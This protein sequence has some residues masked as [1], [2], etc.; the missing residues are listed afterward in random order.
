MW[1]C[2]DLANYVICSKMG[3]CDLTPNKTFNVPI[4]LPPM[5]FQEPPNEA[6][7]FLPNTKI[8]IPYDMFSL[9]TTLGPAKKLTN[10][11]KPTTSGSQSTIKTNADKRPASDHLTIDQHSLVS[12]ISHYFSRSLY[13]LHMFS[14]YFSFFFCLS[15]KENASLFDSVTD[16]TSNPNP[17]PKRTRTNAMRAGNT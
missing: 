8:Y 4:K 5:Y 9:I 10:A 17:N 12:G 14:T 13:L 2:C 11:L 7:G 3:Q 6:V 1:A 15:L 16:D